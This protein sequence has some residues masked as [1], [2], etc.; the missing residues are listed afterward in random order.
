VVGVAVWGCGVCGGMGGCGGVGVW[1]CG[2]WW[3]WGCG[4]C[5]GMGG[6]GGVGGVVVWWVWGCGGVG[7]SAI[8][9]SMYQSIN[10]LLW[11]KS[12]PHLQCGTWL[13]RS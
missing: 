3:V 4:V 10:S 1:W 2:V 8:K 12:R 11:K 6:C 5:G 13:E 7:K 9:I